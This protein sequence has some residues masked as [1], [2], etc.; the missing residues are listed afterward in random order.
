M[1]RHG[2]EDAP[3]THHA[4][5]QAFGSNRGPMRLRDCSE[6][7]DGLVR[8]WTGFGLGS[9]PRL[10]SG[11]KMARDDFTESS[12]RILAERVGFLC[13]NPDCGK[14]T[15]GPHSNVLKSLKKGEAAHITAASPDGPR[16]D[17]RLT[18]DDRRSI[19]NG[20]WLCSSC[21][22]LIDK[23]EIRFT[24]DVVRAWKKQA[25]Q[26]AF[27]RLSTGASEIGTEKPAADVIEDVLRRY[28]DDR[29]SE[30]DE[31]RA[32]SEDPDKL[33]H[34]VEPHYSLLKHGVRPVDASSVVVRTSEADK[35]DDPYKAVAEKGDDPITELVKLLKA[36]KRLCIA[37]D[38]G[39]GKSI[40]TRRLLAFLCSDPGQKALFDGKPCL[41]VRWEPRVR[42]WPEAFDE[43]GLIAALAKAVKPAVEAAGADVS[44]T[45]VAEWSIREGRV[46]LILDALDQ[47]TNKQSI[48]SLEESLH[49]GPVQDCTLVLTSRA[50]AVTDHATMFHETKGWRFGRIETFDERQQEQYLAGLKGGGLRSLFPNYEEVKQLLG[51]PV[52]LAMIRD[53]AEDGRLIA[54]RTRGDLY[55]QVHDRLT[56]RAARK[57]GFQPNGDQIARW[58]EILAAT[59]CQMMVGGFYNY[60][61]QGTFPVRD[62]HQGASR[63]CQEPILPDEWRVIESV[64]GLTDR[65]ILEGAT[66][67]NLCWK[68]RGMMEFYCGLHLARNSQPGWVRQENDSHGQEWERCGDAD[69]RRLASDQEWYWAWRFAIEMSPVVWKSQPSTLLASLSELFDR[70]ESGSRP[71][72]LIYRAWPL[73]NS[74]EDGSVSLLGGAEVIRRFRREFQNLLDPQAPDSVAVEFL[75][76]FVRCPPAELG[77]DRQGFVMGS[78]EGVGDDDERPQ[79]RVLLTPFELQAT[80][81]TRHQYRL[82]DPRYEHEIDFRVFGSFE[83][84]SIG[85]FA[86]DDKCPMINLSW[87]DAWAFCRW[88]G[89]RLPTEAEWEYACRAGTQT[90]FC[91]GDEEVHLDQFA[92]FWGNSQRKTHPVGRKRPNDWGLYDMHGNAR[93]WCSDWFGEYPSQTIKNTEG[94]DV[95]THRVHRGGSWEDDANGCRSAHRKG[96][97]SGRRLEPL[98]VRVAVD[99]PGPVRNRA[100]PGA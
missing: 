44:P 49:S 89:G 94:P 19:R 62:V 12:A 93:E 28:C 96:D 5:W 43:G 22:T 85:L 73:L 76:G 4:G 60:A 87:Y 20:I 42:S 15:I 61:V 99:L 48:A 56:L 78:P 1:P 88:V 11:R 83:H 31:A 52:V 64:S 30:W 55:L 8:Y 37:E 2:C 71:N 25:E 38:A 97:E 13:S 90:A 72:E 74:S 14:A 34:Y 86:P 17:A 68:H 26:E 45:E 77:I 100:E 46:F 58:G 53:L 92:W 80:P 16:Y 47:V 65:C 54:F 39:A 40:F 82:Y 7:E 67:E 35:R 70:P 21:H 41:V 75:G 57:L 6:R 3:G 81:V 36:S 23:D 98:G 24:T 9:T 69:V 79:H 84:F 32:D 66:S 33:T 51:I 63:R 50:Y 59:A 29:V 18:S 10:K 95:G 27:R 91:F